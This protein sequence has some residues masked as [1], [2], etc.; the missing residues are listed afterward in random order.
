MK[1]STPILVVG[2]TGLLGMEIVRLLRDAGK[3]VRA[4]VRASADPA[5]R[6]LLRSSGAETAEADLKDPASLAEVCRGLATVVSTA[7]ATLSRSEGD[8]I[9]TVDEE[10]Q[11]ALVDA[12]AKAGVKH[13]VHVSFAPVAE[14][15][16]LQ[17]AKRKVE[18]RLAGS[19]MSFTI[20]QPVHFLE[21][22]L[23]PALGFHP[24]QGKAR[25]LGSGE[26]PVS[27]IS[28][29]DV[30][31]FAVAA[32]DGGKFAG[33]VLPLG[34][35]DPLSPLQVLQL[36]E[37]LGGPSVVVEH[38]TESALIAQLAGAQDA[39]EEAYAALMLATA[40]G[41]VVDPRPAIELL[42]GR[43]ITIRDYASDCMASTNN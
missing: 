29:R 26:R 28:F 23:G 21:V 35:P 41:Q 22:W 18:E 32:A 40:R 7:S 19:G 25:I 5:K 42:P 9:K 38:V 27:W 15:F 17:R 34:G 33:K 14:D 13:F 36:F 20:L 24:A 6:E 3:P 4:V 39:L 43:L 10:G 37:Q 2:A 31:R 30:A 11:L 8:S 12:A 1:D 16:A